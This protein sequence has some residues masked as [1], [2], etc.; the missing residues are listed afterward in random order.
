MA[1]RANELAFHNLGEDQLSVVPLEQR[2]NVRKLGC[3]GQ[4]VP[5]HRRVMKAATAI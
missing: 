3:P 2:A 5:A 1:V 4:V